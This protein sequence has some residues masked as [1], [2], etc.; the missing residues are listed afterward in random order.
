MMEVS[1]VLY[2]RQLHDGKNHLL[3][4]SK[5]SGF[6]NLEIEELIF[7]DYG[8]VRMSNFSSLAE[9]EKYWLHE[10]LILMVFEIK[11]LGATEVPFSSSMT[12]YSTSAAFCWE[13]KLNGAWRDSKIL[14]VRAHKNLMDQLVVWVKSWD[15]SLRSFWCVLCKFTVFI[16][17]Y[18]SIMLVLL[19]RLFPLSRNSSGRSHWFTSD[20]VFSYF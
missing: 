14:R 16:F 1:L 3:S 8:I 19:V 4:D 5:I 18:F 13:I 12:N 2:V 7:G 10:T 15:I 9:K 20:L 6:K 11:S 17:S